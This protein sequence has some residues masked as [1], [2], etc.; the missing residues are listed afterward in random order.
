[1]KRSRFLRSARLLRHDQAPEPGCMRCG[2][3]GTTLDDRRGV[4]DVAL[5][6]AC[7]DELGATPMDA[8]MVWLPWLRLDEQ[9]RLELWRLHSGP[10]WI[11]TAGPPS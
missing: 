4:L 3:V 2:A 11:P 6:I 10:G 7:G 8:I 5:C 9:R 1:M